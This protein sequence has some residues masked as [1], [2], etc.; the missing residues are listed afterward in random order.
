MECSIPGFPVLHYLLEFA[1]THVHWVSDAIQPSHP[2]LP[3]SPAFNLP[4]HQGLFQWV[5]S[6]YQVAKVSEIQLQPQSFQWTPE[7]ISFRIDWFDVLAVQGSLKSLLQHHSSKASILWRSAFFM[8]QLSH[9]Y[10]TTGKTINKYNFLLKSKIN[11]AFCWN[12][13]GHG[14]VLQVS[15]GLR[16]IKCIHGIDLTQNGAAEHRRVKLKT[17]LWKLFKWSIGRKWLKKMNRISVTCE[18]ISSCLIY[19]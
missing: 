18:I 4:Q 13:K 6:S 10:T 2:L 3:S 7:L 17:G 14:H 19:V 12:P 15:P 11:K 16:I 5:R 8:V 9:L 1:Q